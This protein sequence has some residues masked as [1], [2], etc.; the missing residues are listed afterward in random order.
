MRPLY[1]TI[2]L[3]GGLLMAGCT[4]GPNYVRPKVT[5][6]KNF[7]ETNPMTTTN[8]PV[9]EWWKTFKDPEL[10]KLIEGAL[11]QNYD[12]QAAY[13]RVR[14]SRFQRNIVAADLF[15]QVDADGGY[16][17]SH[18][19]KNVVLPLGGGGGGSSSKTSTGGT[20]TK[21]QSHAEKDSSSSDSSSASGNSSAG[22][23]NDSA[24]D[25]QLSPL[26]KGGLPGADTDLYQVGFDASWEIDVFGAKRRQVEAANAEVQVAANRRHELE[27]SIVAEVARNYFALRG[28]QARLAIAE[29]NLADQN[30]VLELTRSRARSGLAMEADV[31]R[32]AAEAATTSAEIP[33]L[34]AQ[35]REMIHA[36]SVLLGREP[37]ALE[38][39]LASGQALPATP[40]IVPIGLPSQLIE[41]RPDIQEAEREI[42][43]GNARIGSAEA[44]LLPKFALVASA[45][46]DSSTYNNLFDLSSRY[47]LVSPTVTWR[48]FD[49]GRILS[50]I[51]LQKS[52]R[53]EARLQYQ[54][55][56]LKALQE[57]E[58]SLVNYAMESERIHT[59]ENARDQNR[60]A[61]HLARQRYQHGLITFLEVL[62]AERTVLSSEDALAQSSISQVIDL[63][64]LYKALGG[65]WELA[66]P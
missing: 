66:G 34:R 11:T 44:D 56:V 20:G 27:L 18:G 52:I 64:T 33:P 23:N 31:A 36:L 4:I 61:L 55:S 48:I 21:V 26:G 30:E 29:T 50:N 6:S 49:A 42:A 35:T 41:R 59:L 57:V 25:N 2:I 9:S 46:L 43:A 58:D 15:P 22:G 13:A 39:E 17:F 63:V 8:Q 5:L 10:D 7:S 14:Q 62:D 32:A 3:L 47:F 38:N 53:E 40:P 24:F 45:G 16:A 12:L 28:A 37:A 51:R 60:L 65:G 54:A 19:S 1:F